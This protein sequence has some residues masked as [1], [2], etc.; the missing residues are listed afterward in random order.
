MPAHDVT[1]LPYR[2]AVLCYLYDD[3]GC[4]LMLHRAQN[5]NMGMYS[6]I[7]GKVEVARGESPHDAAAREIKEEVGL[8]MAAADL[9]LTGIVSES[10]YEGEHHWLIFLFE[11]MRPIQ[12]AEIAN[13]QFKEGN[14]EWAKIEDVEGLDIPATDRQVMWPLVRAHRGGGFFMV[15]IDCSVEPMRWEVRE[16]HKRDPR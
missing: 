16:S 8:E 11:V 7:G 3:A 4:V 1:A 14:L 2:V 5:P 6:P 9:H 12:R 15:H 13:M 10:A